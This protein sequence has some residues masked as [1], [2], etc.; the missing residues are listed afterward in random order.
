MA[1]EHSG[2]AITA[3]VIK[4]KLIDL[5]DDSSEAGNAFFS[6]G[7]H[8]RQHRNVGNKEKNDSS[9][10]N[11][12]AAGGGTSSSNKK[13]TDKQRIKCYK[14][15]EFGH[16][17]SQCTKE[18]NQQYVIKATNA[19]SA[20]FLSGNY[21]KND[22]YLDSG[23]SVHMTPN[24]NIV[25]NP[26]FTPQI[27]EIIAA[28]KSAMP[29]LCCGD[30][31]IITKT[32]GCRYDVTLKEV[33]CVPNLSTNLISIKNVKGY[34]VYDP[35]KCNITTS[36][37]VIV[38]ENTERK[39][40]VDDSITVSVGDTIQNDKS[41]SYVE[42]SEKEIAKKTSQN[43][44]CS[45]ISSESE[46]LNALT[47]LDST[48]Q[49]TT[50][51]EEDDEPELEVITK[52]IR[53]PPERYGFTNQCASSSTEVIKDPVTIHEALEARTET[54]SAISWE[55]RKQTVALSSMEAEYMAIAEAC[56]EAIYLRMLLCELTGRDMKERGRPGEWHVSTARADRPIG[57]RKT[58]SRK[59]R[60]TSSLKNHLKSMH[61]EEFTLFEKANKEKALQKMK[62]DAGKSV[63]PL[64]EAKKQF[65]LEEVI[66]KANKWDVN[67]VNS[68]KIDKLIGEMI[69]L[70]N[71]PFNF[72]EGLGFRRLI[73]EIARRYN[74]RGR[75][76][77]TEFVCKEL[78]GKIAIKVKEL[79]KKF[80]HMSF[81]SDIWSDPSSNASLL[82][83]TCHGIA[84]DFERSSIILKCETFDDRHT[85]DIIA[86][87]F[88]TMLSKW[89]ISNDQVHCMIRDGGS[90]MKRAMRLAK[91]Q[92]LDCAVHKMQLAIQ[93]SLNSQEN[94]K[95]V[96]ESK[97][98][99]NF[100]INDS[101][102]D[103]I[104]P[105]EWKIIECC[106]ELLKPLKKPH[107]NLAVL[108]LISSVI[109]IIRMLTQKVSNYLTASPE[110]PIY[111]AAKTLKAG[112]SG[113]FS[114]LLEE[115][116][117]YIIATYLD[118][119]YKN[120]IFTSLT[121]EK[122]KDDI[123]KISR[124]TEDIL[125]S[126]TISPSTERAKKMRMT[127]SMDTDSER[128][129]T[130]GT[131]RQS[132]LISDLA[133]ILD[134]SSNDESQNIVQRCKQLANQF[135]VDM[136][137]KV[138]SERLRYISLNRTKLRAENYIHLQDAVANDANLNPNNLGRMVILPSSFVNSPRYLHEYTQD[139]FVYV[140][141]HGRPDLFVTFT[142]N[143]AWPEI[144]NELM[145]G[146]SAI[147]RHDVVAR[148][149]RLKVKK[150]NGCD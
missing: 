45:N 110:S 25:K 32:D 132:C 67:N 118:P 49:Q 60:T 16:Y 150:T 58:Y 17:K 61:T 128:P 22:F 54:S 85:G 5:S 55:S 103:P 7:Q 90:N 126:R 102:I 46:Y 69:P 52:R 50:A 4:T 12:G 119:R 76:F 19:F 10:S 91:L 14:C 71:L 143:P 134:S 89:N 63:T 9:C 97:D 57:T 130:S 42:S 47:D 120:K 27:K 135:Y 38:H 116:N 23:A 2:I 77:F 144:V 81:T 1:I 64:Q 73:Q 24:V 137:V 147:D 44:E 139:A 48:L 8:Y 105:E 33:S 11:N 88:D 28:N 83:L 121:E 72:V 123:L 124:N 106:V 70:Q 13:K 145:P 115:E 146:Q 18:Q 15:K 107:V 56:K 3:D 84:S 95:N 111:Y 141:T 108:T 34:R 40:T 37:D 74:F 30:V 149:F 82:S 109:P 142:C 36:R 140:R 20:V 92:D 39:N 26:C 129:G 51:S 87:K 41:G 133:M 122:I 43:D 93:S 114:T 127:D 101:E 98:A 6:R 148:V 117:S 80:D 78:Y 75:N 86:E 94:I 79:L 138:E 136:Y 131:G 68:K 100:N 104:L 62:T 96:F 66:Q 29:V 112:I 53:K 99:L 21:C 113:K 125:A 59:G 31:N 65:S 35:V